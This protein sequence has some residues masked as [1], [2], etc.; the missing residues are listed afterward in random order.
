MARLVEIQS[1]GDAPSEVHLEVGDL[2]Q[3][4][5]SGGVVR[6]GGDVVSL[7]GAFLPAVSGPAG[8]VVAPAGPPSI[9]L[10]SARER[11]TAHV[12]VMTGDPWSTPQRR[13]IRL[14][15]T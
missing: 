12:D 9:V 1:A 10:F 8:E 6:D 5:A 7:L 2:L 13:A 14:V 3:I 15:V 4:G 11:G